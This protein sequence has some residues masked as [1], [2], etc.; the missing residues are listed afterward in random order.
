MISEVDDFLA[1]E[2]WSIDSLIRAAAAFPS[3]VASCPQ[4]TYAI[5]TRYNTIPNFVEW[6]HSFKVPISIRRYESIQRFTS[7][8]LDIYT[9]YKSN[10]L[11]L[12]DIIKH[13]DHY[14]FTEDSNKLKNDLGDMLTE[15]TANKAQMSEIVAIIETLYVVAISWRLK[16]IL[17]I[18]QEC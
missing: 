7:E 13:P 16:M 10:L 3:N 9:E 15:R 18:Q 5:L 8:L 1:D 2:E 12:N 17:T 14:N 4:R 6:A 11:I